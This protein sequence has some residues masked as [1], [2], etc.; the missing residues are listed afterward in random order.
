ML[1]IRCGNR[2]AETSLSSCLVSFNEKGD[3]NTCNLPSLKH[4][5]RFTLSVLSGKKQTQI[6][7]ED[8]LMLKVAF[9]D[10]FVTYLKIIF[11]FLFQNYALYTLCKIINPCS[12]S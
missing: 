1:V 2:L 12:F 6:N 9:S 3:L 8:L 5:I 11:R 4:K 10:S 7:M